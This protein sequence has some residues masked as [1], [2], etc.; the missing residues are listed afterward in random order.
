MSEA[1]DGKSDNQ[2]PNQLTSLVPQFDP[3][4]HDLE[5]YTQKVELLTEI[6]PQGKIDELITRL[7]LGT[8]GA[9]FQK[10]QLQRSTLLTGDKSGVEKLVTILGG[11]WGRYHWNVSMR[12]SRRQFSDVYSVQMNPM[13]RS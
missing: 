4:Q 3:A 13:I 7:I 2:V 6:W 12:S 8:S 1:S 9:A 5:Q 11:H 10:L